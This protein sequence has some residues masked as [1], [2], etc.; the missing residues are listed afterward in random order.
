MGEA[1]VEGSISTGRRS[2]VWKWGNDGYE[3]LLDADPEYGEFSDTFATCL[4][5]GFGGSWRAGVRDEGVEIL[6]RPGERM[7]R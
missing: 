7:M 2:L 6:M 5:Y 1:W 3:S 4:R